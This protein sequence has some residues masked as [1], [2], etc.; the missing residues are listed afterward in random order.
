MNNKLQNMTI[1]EL[2]DLGADVEI[3]F[4][5]CKNEEEADKKIECFGKPH[6][7]EY[8]GTKW[9][10]IIKERAPGANTAVIAYYEED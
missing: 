7:S 3:S 2:E 8:E 4:H 9:K 10:E 6:G 1:K 5:A